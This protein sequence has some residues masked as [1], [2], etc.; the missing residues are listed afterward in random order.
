MSFKKKIQEHL[1]DQSLPEKYLRLLVDFYSCYK[2]TLE[3][4][5]ID[6]QAYEPLF[7]LYL[8]LLIQQMKEPY[9]FSPYHQQILTPFDY[10]QFGLDF[11]RPLVDMRISSLQGQETLKLIEGQI[12]QGHNAILL[13]NHQVEADPQALSLLLESEFPSLA[14]EMIFVAG[15][16][17]LT[18]PLA[19]PFSMGRNLLCI[20]S[21]RY[22][23]HPPE[24]KT[25]KQLHNKK[26]MELMSELLAEGGKCIYVAPSG[27][28]D[29]PGPDGAVEVAPFDP[30]SIEMFYLMAQRSKVPTH[31]YPL[32][33]ATYDL[34]PPPQTVQ[35]E[36][37]ELRKTQR[38]G[39]HAHF[40]EEIH[41]EDFPG[42]ELSDK[43]ARRQSRADFICS[44]VRKAY[45][46]F[47]S[48]GANK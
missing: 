10:Y 39:I 1:I 38:G 41:M 43:H 16:R 33:L 30:Q 36:L 23:D 42:S 2:S 40:G 24:L 12:A 44:L 11:V 48:S 29:R 34:L 45:L 35:V 37:G 3:D 8:D 27:G 25:K 20:Y 15:E 19:A 47:P 14:K 4:H 17:V 13:A 5:G 32:S 6:I 26:T 9:S 28:R 7:D 21:K 46:Q 22:I 18:D 31:F